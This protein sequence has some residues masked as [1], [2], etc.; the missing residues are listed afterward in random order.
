MCRITHWFDFIK[1]LKVQPNCKFTRDNN[2]FTEQDFPSERWFEV[3]ASLDAAEQNR[4]PAGKFLSTKEI[5]LKRVDSPEFQD[6]RYHLVT[7]LSYNTVIFVPLCLR[8]RVTQ[9]EEDRSGAWSEST[10]NPVIPQITAGV[11]VG[12][13]SLMR[14]T[15]R[16]GAFTQLKRKRTKIHRL[17]WQESEETNSAFSAIKCIARP[18][19]TFC[20]LWNF[21]TFCDITNH[22]FFFSPLYFTAAGLGMSLAALHV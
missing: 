9:D 17:I 1:V 20:Y 19:E 6:G 5:K 14:F 22:H 2:A 13:I 7:C 18:C 16:A 8:R 15:D 3:S 10:R 11:T 21:F 4:P 12:A